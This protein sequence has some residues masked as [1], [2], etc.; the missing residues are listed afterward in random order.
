MSEKEIK[1]EF[2]RY[3]RQIR[4]APFGQ[5]SQEALARSTAVIV[6]C[7]ALGSVQAST[8]VRAGVGRVRLIDRDFVELNNLQRQVLYDENDVE[9]GMPKAIA[10]KNK[11]TQVNSS[12]EIESI[13]E[14]LNFAN[15]AERC[16]DADVI[17]DGTDNFETR[18]LVNDFSVNKKIPWVYGGCIGSDGQS[19]TIVPDETPCLHCLMNEGP[20]AAGSTATCDTAGILAPIINVIASIQ[21]QEAIKILAGKLDRINRK[22][23]SVGLWDNSIRQLDISN[24]RQDIECPVCDRSEFK[25]LDGVKGSRSAVLCGRNAVQL[26][27][28]DKRQVCFN[29]L[30]SKLAPIGPI[31]R[32]QFLLQVSD[33]DYSMTVFQDGRVIVNGTEDIAKAKSLFAQWIGT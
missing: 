30:E 33:Q 6:G 4:F 3:A 21:C 24:L 9:S 11:L 12:I 10:A 15:I 31:K 14:D 23:L 1:P 27:P 18:F 19:M 17:L 7:G 32:N 13:V 28:D 20:P 26:S 5:E 22:L 2:Q 8:L 25:W 29:E 16:G